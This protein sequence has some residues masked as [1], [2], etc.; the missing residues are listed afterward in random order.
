MPLG[1]SKAVFGQAAAA[2]SA[3]GGRAF[4]HNGTSSSSSGNFSLDKAATYTVSY[5]SAPFSDSQ[6][7]SMVFWFRLAQEGGNIDDPASRLIYMTDSDQSDLWGLTFGNGTNV[8][9]MNCLNSSG[10]RLVHPYGSTYA[11]NPAFM[12]AI[13]DGSWRCIMVSMDSDAG[14][15]IGSFYIGGSSTN[16]ASGGALT[17]TLNSDNM[18]Y[19]ALRNNNGGHNTNYGTSFETGAGFELGPVWLYDSYLDFTS[20][21]VRGYFYNSSNTDGYVDGGSDGTAGGAPTPDVYI[22][23][24]ETTLE[25]AGSSTPTVNTVTHNSGAIVIIPTSEGPGSGDTI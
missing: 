18:K 25:V 17:S 1:F 10:N 11:N 8:T 24:G 15:G 6:H 5:S 13:A 12:S 23:H 20:S 9:Y 21:T 14:N 19:I 4:T 16:E 22:K 3:T 2:V 7:F